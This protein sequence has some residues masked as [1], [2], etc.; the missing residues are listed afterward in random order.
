MIHLFKDGGLFFTLPITFLLLLIIVM[1]ILSINKRNE[2]KKMISLMA[3]IAWFT[4]AW[5]YLGRTFALIKSFDAIQAAGEI[6]PSVFAPGLKMAL[7]S[8]LFGIIIFIVAQAG[9]IVLKLRNKQE[10]FEK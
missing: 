10:F 1:F 4:I 6:S 7:V 8:P 3:S 2:N 9:I 5:G